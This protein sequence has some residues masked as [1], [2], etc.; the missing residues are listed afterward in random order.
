MPRHSLILT[1]LCVLLSDNCAT[2]QVNNAFILPSCPA[3][4]HHWKTDSFLYIPQC[5]PSG[6][7]QA[8]GRS[9]AVT[10]TR[11]TL[12]LFITGN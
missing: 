9:H 6:E 3:H 8:G 2:D 12:F 4:I 11:I 5:R 10:A 7:S 1:K